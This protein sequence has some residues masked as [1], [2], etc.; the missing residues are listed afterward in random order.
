M[1]V[2]AGPVLAVR[3][4]ISRARAEPS[5]P[6]LNFPSL[7]ARHNMGR[8]EVSHVGIDGHGAGWGQES[9]DAQGQFSAPYF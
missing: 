9:S 2:G 8:R 1:Q 6:S 3:N 7:A 5:L 4:S